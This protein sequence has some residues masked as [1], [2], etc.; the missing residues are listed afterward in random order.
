M[1]TSAFYSTKQALRVTEAIFCNTDMLLNRILK[2]RNSLKNLI[3]AE[4]F[5]QKVSKMFSNLRQNRVLIEVPFEQIT[6]NAGCRLA[7]IVLYTWLLVTLSPSLI[8]CPV[9]VRQ[10]VNTTFS[11]RFQEEFSDF[12]NLG[13]FWY[14]SYVSKAYK[15]QLGVDALHA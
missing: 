7:K 10:S 6:R 4:N 15:L 1:I 8:V 2:N 5:T 13:C 3:I 14:W 11:R 12:N 9:S